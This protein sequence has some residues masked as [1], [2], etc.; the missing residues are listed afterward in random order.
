MNAK[1]A[2]DIT[3]PVTR[4]RSDGPYR[5]ASSA[6]PT[7]HVMASAAPC[8]SRAA[9]S[10][11]RPSANANS[12]VE[13]DKAMSPPTIG[14]LRPMRSDT[15]PIGI[16]TV[17]SVTPNDAKSSPI[18]VGDAPSR[19]LRSGR[20]GTAMEYATMSVKA[21][22]VTSTTVIARECRTII[23]GPRYHEEHKGHEEGQRS[24]NRVLN[25]A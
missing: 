15:A 9:K 8:T 22:N 24:T 7:T 19:P 14:G 12:S 16:E 17:S 23:A 4:P 20:T 1:L 3:M 13:A 11:G 21:A 18:I 2:P 5:S 10:H 6:K 25:C